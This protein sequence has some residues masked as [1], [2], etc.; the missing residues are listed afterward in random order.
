MRGIGRRGAENKHRRMSVDGE[1]VRAGAGER[2][3]F[4]YTSEARS[5][6]CGWAERKARGS[7]SKVP[8]EVTTA[9]RRRAVSCGSGGQSASECPINT[10]SQVYALEN[11]TTHLVWHK[12]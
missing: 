3:G 9:N 11:E 7:G 1:A 2:T 6:R 12:T 8:M 5:R 4:W 10:V